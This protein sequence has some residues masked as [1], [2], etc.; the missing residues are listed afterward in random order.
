MDT[1]NNNLA[2]ILENCAAKCNMCFG[3]CLKEGDI[4]SLAECI[5]LDRQCAEICQ[6]TA[7]WIY[8]GYQHLESLKKLCSEIC[9]SCAVECEKHEHVHCRECA[10]A[11]RACAKACS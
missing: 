8:S 2:E 5:G 4:E 10:E 1:E 6:L 7:N 3:D 9:I 11:C